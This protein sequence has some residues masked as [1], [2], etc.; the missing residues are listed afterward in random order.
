MANYL[1]LKIA[2]G[3]I[4]AVIVLELLPLIPFLIP[5]IVNELK[6]ASLDV[7][8]IGLVFGRYVLWFVVGFAILCLLGQIA[9]SVG[10]MTF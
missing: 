1:T 4:L 8:R 5:A 2:G 7:L 6:E 10:W 9:F 3:I